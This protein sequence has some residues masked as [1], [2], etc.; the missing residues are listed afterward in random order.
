MDSAKRP[1]FKDIVSEVDH[2][3]EVTAGYLPLSTAA[4]AREGEAMCDEESRSDTESPEL[5]RKL[6]KGVKTGAGITI[7]LQTCDGSPGGRRL[8]ENANETSV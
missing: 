8:A 4:A 2:V 7:Q 6:I 5:V 1:S 3:M